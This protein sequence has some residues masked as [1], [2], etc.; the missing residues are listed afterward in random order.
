MQSTSGLLKF[1]RFAVHVMRTL[2]E[3][4][5]LSNNY[6]LT[7]FDTNCTKFVSFTSQC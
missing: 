1:N 4:D 3:N 5:A 2:Q 6:I 7:V